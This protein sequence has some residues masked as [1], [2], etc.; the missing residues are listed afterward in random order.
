MV[1]EP[2]RVRLLRSFDPEAP[3]GAEVPDPYYADDEAFGAVLAMVWPS[4]LAAVKMAVRL[5]R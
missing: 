3:S 2:E 4:G 1:P 5:S